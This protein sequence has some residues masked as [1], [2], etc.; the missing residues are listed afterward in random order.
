LNFVFKAL[1]LRVETFF[2]KRFRKIN[3]LLLKAKFKILVEIFIFLATERGDDENDEA[4]YDIATSDINTD[5]TSED[6]SPQSLNHDDSNPTPNHI[7]NINNSNNVI[8][9]KT[10]ATQAQPTTKHHQSKD[11]THMCSTLKGGSDTN[12]KNFKIPK[13]NN[14]VTTTANIALTKIKN[15]PETLI[16]ILSDHFGTNSKIPPSLLTN[17]ESPSL[18]I[19]SVNSQN[20]YPPSSSSS[21]SPSISTTMNSFDFNNQKS[22]NYYHPKKS[23]FRQYMMESSSSTTVINDNNNSTNTSNVDVKIE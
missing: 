11:L 20:D 6:R 23:Q 1:N 4:L 16:S 13:Q 5:E 8:K 9:K 21:S 15:E 12:L 2:T 3:Y 17:C 18:S 14:K 10:N 22:T 7:N 19:S